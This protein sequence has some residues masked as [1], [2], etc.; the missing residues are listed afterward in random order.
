MQQAVHSKLLPR[1]ILV[2]IVLLSML[3]GGC[4]KVSNLRY[5]LEF[6]RIFGII[7]EQSLITNEV[8]WKEIQKAVSDSIPE[9]NC[10]T[11]VH[12]GIDYTLKLLNDGHS[13]FRAP[14]KMNYVTVPI[15]T[16]KFIVAPMW[17][18]Q[19]SPIGYIKLCGLPTMNDSIGRSYAL[20]IRE[21]LLK[22]DRR[23]TL[24]GWIIDLRENLGGSLESES[25]GLSPLFTDSII[26]ITC[27]NKNRNKNI[28]CNKN[29]F[30][31]GDVV[32][33][34]ITC[35]SILINKDKKIAVLID[36]NTASA[37][38]FLSLAFKIQKNTKLFGCKTRGLTSHLR[39]FIFAKDVELLLA[40]EYYCDRDKKTYKDG[41][42]P[43]VE[44]KKDE[45]LFKAV[46]WIRSTD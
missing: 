30:K 14:F 35:D 16:M 40:V 23:S 3:L 12:K 4:T 8:D 1:R 33:R 27:D 36:N 9:L 44:C 17:L 46:D 2:S 13:H 24:S 28:V 42:Y 43:D 34:S 38:E 29:S 25:L 5:E 10:S 19:G 26:G 45:S 31:S 22:L 39:Y 20:N 41:I 18:S 21:L 32:Q 37:G 7:K 6:Y 15:D 11:N